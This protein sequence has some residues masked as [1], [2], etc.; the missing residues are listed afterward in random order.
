MGVVA[1]TFRTDEGR[2]KKEGPPS[3]LHPPT[4]PPLSGLSCGVGRVKPRRTNSL[5]A[6]LPSLRRG[7]VS[8][9]SWQSRLFQSLRKTRHQY[10]DRRRLSLS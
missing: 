8:R 6:P 5:L 10:L 1:K 2:S 4:S 3:S 9:A 7:V